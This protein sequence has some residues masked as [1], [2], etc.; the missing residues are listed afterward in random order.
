MEI[1]ADKTAM[2]LILIPLFTLLVWAVY[3]YNR[4]IRDRN[5]VKTAWS[6]IDVQL[7]RR[8]DL[9]PNLVSTVKAYAAY[10]KSLL[11]TVTELRERARTTEEVSGKGELEGELARGVQRLIALAEAYPDLKANQSFLKL[12]SQLAEVEDHL[13][14]ARRYYNGA[15][16]NINTRIESFPDLLI[17]RLFRFRQAEFFQAG[18]DSRAAIEVKT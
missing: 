1:T 9:V 3:A 4:L 14:Y 18:E 12:Q 11:S 7:R 5:R 15:V 17:A 2:T 13:Q 6:D 10:E 8:H 16:R